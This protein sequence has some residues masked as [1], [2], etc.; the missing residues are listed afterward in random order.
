MTTIV[1]KHVRISDLPDDWR[2]QLPDVSDMRVT[3]LIQE[4]PKMKTMDQTESFVTND[5]AFGI[6]RDRDDIDD[7]DDYVRKL[8]A[9]RF[10]H[11]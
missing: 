9:P 5:P 10:S 11:K 2:K 8:R 6:W 1:I 4:E 7:V 3:I